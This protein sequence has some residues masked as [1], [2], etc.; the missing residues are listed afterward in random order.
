MMGGKSFPK[1][2]ELDKLLDEIDEILKNGGCLG[3]HCTHGVNRTGYIVC[4]YLTHKLMWDGEK[5]LNA[6]KAA[7]SVSVEH[8]EYIDAIKK[9]APKK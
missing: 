3:V 2:E 1:K 6:F 5:A 4:S 7:R 8:D 9:N